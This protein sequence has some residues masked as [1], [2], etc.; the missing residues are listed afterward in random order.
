MV[1]SNVLFTFLFLPIVT[2]VYYLAKDK[3]R[4][5]ILLVASLLFYSFGE[6]WFVFV[7]IASIMINYFLAMGI[8]R[9]EVTGK[10]KLL[11]ILAVFLN[12]ALL[13]FYKY[14][15]FTKYIFD[16]LRHTEYVPFGIHLPIGIS[17]FTFQAM[18]YVIDV[19]R[20]EVKVQ[21]NPFYVALYISF[22]PQL[23]AG[24][25]VRYQTIED[26]IEHRVLNVDKYA[27]G[28]KRFVLGFS[29][30]VIIANNL[31]MI[32]EKYF[33][34]TVSDNGIILWLAAIGYTL[35]IFF[36]FSGYS[37]MAIGLGKMFGFDFPENFN[38]PYI[39]RSVTD[40]W[41]RWHISLSS[42]F[43]DYVYIPLG[44]S[45]VKVFRHIFNMF[46]VWALTGLWHGAKFTFVAWGLWYFAWLVVEKYLVKPERL[47]LIL[48]VIWRILTLLCVIMGWVVFNS[49]GLSF[50]L[51]Y[52]MG[53]LGRGNISWSVTGEII[54][55][56]R[57]YGIYL[58]FG[59]I[60]STPILRSLS[61]IKEKTDIVNNVCKIAE[62][63]FYFAVFLW[64]VSFIVLGAHNPF[65]YFNF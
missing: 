12:L 6:A 22:F 18:S 13:F 8:D 21:K 29:K 55:V 37:D 31:A 59:I 16:N 9:T 19:Y 24:P 64:A 61:K 26:Q 1:F 40:F 17:F 20:K 52:C 41:R 44:G 35:Q 51:T 3:Y 10:R 49:P 57:E 7:M 27:E 48:K 53:M 46:V 23:I 36:D 62:P 39:A 28:I 50:A 38:Y 65:I 47:P 54:K 25:I 5:Y 11:M 30:K 4:N 2:A 15:D 42:W 32:S 43:R 33:T 14:L 63:V 58:A 60:F 45:R 34:D 56:L